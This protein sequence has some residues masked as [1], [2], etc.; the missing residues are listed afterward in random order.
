MILCCTLHKN[1]LL[2]WLPEEISNFNFVPSGEQLGTFWVLLL[3]TAVPHSHSASGCLPD[4]L[5]G[6]SVKSWA[7]AASR[8]EGQQKLMRVPELL[9]RSSTLLPNGESKWAVDKNYLMRYKMARVVRTIE[10]VKNKCREPTSNGDAGQ[11]VR[12]PKR[13]MCWV[14]AE[15]FL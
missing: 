3:A 13:K 2:Y 11:Q 15:S 12:M 4:I 7:V 1:I 8:A 5:A 9:Q 14:L 6:T 10:Y